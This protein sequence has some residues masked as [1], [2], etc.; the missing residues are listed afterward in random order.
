MYIF[1]EQ[2]NEQ[3][4]IGRIQRLF[5]ETESGLPVMHTGQLRVVFAFLLFLL[6]INMSLII[7]MSSNSAVNSTVYEFHSA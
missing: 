1:P 4:I 7:V 5:A 6:V 3:L 2:Y